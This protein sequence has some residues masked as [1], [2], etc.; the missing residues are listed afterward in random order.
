MPLAIPIAAVASSVVGG[1]LA[2]KSQAKAQKRA[3]AQ[4][5]DAVNELSGAKDSVTSSPAYASFQSLFNNFAQNPETFSPT[6]LEEIKARQANALRDTYTNNL[7]DLWNRAGAS[8]SYRDS[9]TRGAEGV[10]TQQLGGQ[11][12]DMNRG[13]DVMAAQ[14]RPQDVSQLLGMLQ[15]FS[16]LQGSLS[17]PIANARLGAASQMANFTANP[18]ADLLKGV[19]SIGTTLGTTDTGGNTLFS[20]FMKSLMGGGGGGSTQ[21]GGDLYS[22]PGMMSMGR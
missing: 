4:I 21:T 2:S 3:G 17:Q 13:V 1:T 22:I 5:E 6:L 12:A 19:G 8:G 14:Q 7:G 16:G 15:A 9:S 10:L 11:L 20:Q 18:L